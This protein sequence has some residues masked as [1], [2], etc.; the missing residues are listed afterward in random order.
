MQ[1]EIN[2]GERINELMIERDIDTK[3]L[4]KD[5][6]VTVSTVSRWRNN[7]KY[8]RLSQIVK[9]ANYLDCSYLA[10]KSIQ[11]LV[12]SRRIL[13]IGKMAQTRIFYL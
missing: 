2:I 12:L 6:G 10:T 1:E 9:I 11:I 3:T 5:I 4:A 8:M 7:A 13:S